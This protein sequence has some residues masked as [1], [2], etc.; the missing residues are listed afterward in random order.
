LDQLFGWVAAVVTLSAFISLA[1]LVG[2]TR[3]LRRRLFLTLFGVGLLPALA[4]GLA[5]WQQT[6]GLG[7]LAD[8]PGLRDAV[9]ASVELA[10]SVLQTRAQDLRSRAAEWAADPAGA[11]PGP[12]KGLLVTGGPQ[13]LVSGAAVGQEERLRSLE[14]DGRLEDPPLLYHTVDL[15]SGQ[16]LIAVWML[17]PELVARLAAVGRGAAGLR[18]LGLYYEQILR[19]RALLVAA[20]VLLVSVLMALL[21]SGALTNRMVRPLADLVEATQRITEGDRAF[22]V[23]TGAVDEVRDLERAFN[24]MTA[25]LAESEARL[26]HSERLAAWQGIARRLAHEIK[27]PLTPIR[28]A[29]HRARRRTENAVVSEALGAIEEETRNL[30]RLA[31]EFSALGRMPAPRRRPV[32]AGAV[33]R[34]V[35]RLYVDE[36][37]SLQIEGSAMIH[38]DEG[39]LRQVWANLLKNAVQAMNGRGRIRVNLHP[40]GPTA[41]LTVEDEGPGLPEDTARVFEPEFTT[42]SSGTGLGLAIVRRIVEDHGGKIRAGNREAG[43]ARFEIDWPSAQREDV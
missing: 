41:R 12:G 39:Q 36:G 38:A 29:V 5:T 7:R 11:N 13:P 14:G 25:Q 32:E 35:G 21:V 17:E 8:A 19:G 3:G 31:E 23:D 20:S 27:N 18:Q 37:V 30:Q 34:E 42:R 24:E 9:D 6:S 4:V 40:T 33:A 22:V 1:L 28:L 26:R 43:G 15:E 16:R 10:R 2:R